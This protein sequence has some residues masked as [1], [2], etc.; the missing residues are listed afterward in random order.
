MPIRSMTGFARVSRSTP[1]GEL[2]LSLKSVNHKGLDLHLHMPMEL[3]SAEPALRSLLRK[4][5]TRGHVQLTV[6]LKRNAA[7]A[8]A[9]GINESMLRAWIESF[10]AAAARFGID[11]QPD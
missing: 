2:T 8:P 6:H 11:S 1:Q 3:D 9:A 5:L 4:R 10:R 7:S